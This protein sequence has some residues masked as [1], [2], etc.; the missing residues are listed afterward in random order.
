[1][2]VKRVRERLLV[3]DTDIGEE[4]KRQVKDLERLLVA[5]RNGELREK[6]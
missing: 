2:I 3:G 5:Y 4:L 6:R 1:M